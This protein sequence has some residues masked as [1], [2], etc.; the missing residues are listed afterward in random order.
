MAWEVIEPKKLKKQ[1]ERLPPVIQEAYK[2]LLADLKNDG[3]EQPS[4]HHYSKLVSRKGDPE[5]HHCHLNKGKPR[6]VVVWR[7]NDFSLEIMEVRYVGTHENAD[8]QRIC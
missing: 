1:V 4:W 7:V 8:Y 6:Y 2:L 5:R 3:P